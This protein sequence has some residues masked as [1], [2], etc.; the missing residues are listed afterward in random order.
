MSD[1]IRTVL[2]FLNNRMAAVSVE[3][4]KKVQEVVSRGDVTLQEVIDCYIEACRR[5]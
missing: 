3:E 5:A 4:K 1:D 2:R